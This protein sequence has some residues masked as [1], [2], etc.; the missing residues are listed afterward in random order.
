[1]RRKEV[2]EG[3]KLGPKKNALSSA[4]AEKPKQTTNKKKNAYTHKKT[5]QKKSAKG[6]EGI[7]ERTCST[8]TA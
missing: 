7:Q 4:V 8:R 5:H 6:G 1:M 3:G 2:G